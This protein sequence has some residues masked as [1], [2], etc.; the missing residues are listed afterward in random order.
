MPSI[1]AREFYHLACLYESARNLSPVSVGYVLH[2]ELARDDRR[3]S[4]IVPGVDKYK[5]LLSDPLAA[6]LLV[7]VVEYEE[8]DRPHLL[9]KSF[10]GVGG[11]GIERV[12]YQL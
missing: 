2:R 11:L 7:H 12:F 4:V 9:Q 10:S 6:F 5:K 8:W 1:L 3:E